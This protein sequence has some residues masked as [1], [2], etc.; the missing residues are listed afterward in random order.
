[1]QE[2]GETEISKIKTMFEVDF[3]LLDTLNDND[4]GYHDDRVGMWQ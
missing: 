4:Q 1:M 2:L 3:E